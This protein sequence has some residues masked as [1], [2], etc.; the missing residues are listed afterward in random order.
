[1]KTQPSLYK[2]AAAYRRDGLPCK[3]AAIRG[4]KILLETVL[5][6][7]LL[8]IEHRQ[9]HTGDVRPRS[10][11]RDLL[12][13]A[14]IVAGPAAEKDS[15]DGQVLWDEFVEIHRRSPA[16]GPQLCSP[17]APPAA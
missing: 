12:D 4:T 1:V 17:A 14:G 3:G 11:D 13:R 2:S 6:I 15:N 9:R 7:L 10:C 8:K 16:L 5:W